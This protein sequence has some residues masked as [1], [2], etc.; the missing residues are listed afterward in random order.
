AL[1]ALAGV[2][3]VALGGGADPSPPVALAGPAE[4]QAEAGSTPDSDL[5]TEDLPATA[6]RARL[7]DHLGARP[8]RQAGQRGRGVK[9][10]VLDSGFKGYRSF[11]GK[12]LPERVQARSFRIDGNL[13]ARDSQHGILCGEVIHTLAPEAELLFANWEP[14][15]PERFLDAVA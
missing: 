12:A 9:V 14:E 1:F 11:L 2:C 6:Q 7:L 8:W 13:E 15:S 3:W 5:P 4:L 10:A